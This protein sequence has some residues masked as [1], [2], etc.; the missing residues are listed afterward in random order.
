MERKHVKKPDQFLQPCDQTGRKGE[1]TYS[2]WCE[3]SRTILTSPRR[4]RGLCSGDLL[5]L[6]WLKLVPGCNVF[7][8]H[9]FRISEKL[10]S[11]G[12]AGCK[13]APIK[14]KLQLLLNLLGAK[15]GTGCTDSKNS[16]VSSAKSLCLY[17]ANGVAW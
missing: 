3:Y 5:L 4:L 1:S 2:V 13:S 12:R 6:G 9:G 8:R 7:Y 11:G 16:E 17:Y 14:P 15:I 10:Y